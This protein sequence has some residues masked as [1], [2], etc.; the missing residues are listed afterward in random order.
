MRVFLL[1][2][3]YLKTTSMLHQKTSKKEKENKNMKIEVTKKM[4][5]VLNKAAKE[6][7]A[8]MKFIF[9]TM[10]ERAYS[11][12]VNALAS[13]RDY[14]YEK[15]VFKVIKVLYPDEYYAMPN[16]LATEDL[17]KLYRNGD[18]LNAYTARVINAMEV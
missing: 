10:T 4:V 5:N 1:P 3:K 12:Y 14:D 8:E 11:I 17:E 7:G 15:G 2:Q 9:E 18:D 16:Y 6:S 13:G